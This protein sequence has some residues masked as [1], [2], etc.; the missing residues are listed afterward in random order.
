MNIIKTVRFCNIQDDEFIYFS[1]RKHHP[2]CVS[3]NFVRKHFDMSIKV[4]HAEQFY[5]HVTATERDW[6]FI[7][8]TKDY[9]YLFAR[10]DWY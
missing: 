8:S 5:S 9:E 10:K 4:F 6:L 7:I 2:F 1:D 3:V